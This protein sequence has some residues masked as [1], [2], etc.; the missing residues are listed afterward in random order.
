T[1]LLRTRRVV[2]CFDNGEEKQADT[3]VDELKHAGIAARRLDL[4]SLGLDTPKGDLNDYLTG[5]GGPAAIRRA[6]RSA[7]WPDARRGVPHESEGSTP[8]Q[9][10]PEGSRAR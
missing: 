1:P 10:H 5:G 9:G 4:R 2:V 3:R 8:G 7:A 6:A